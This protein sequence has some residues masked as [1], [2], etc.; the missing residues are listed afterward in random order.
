[1]GVQKFKFGA[2]FNNHPALA[3]ITHILFRNGGVNVNDF[4]NYTGNTSKRLLMFCNSLVG[5]ISGNKVSGISPIV[6]WNSTDA[7]STAGVS[8]YAL[9]SAESGHAEVLFF[10]FPDHITGGQIAAKGYIDST[11]SS[12]KV[13]P[14]NRREENLL[15]IFFPVETKQNQ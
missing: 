11:Q 2:R 5:S 8:N 9:S 4:G 14:A 12:N 13:Q 6:N 15:H 3:G 7:A 10:V 1:M